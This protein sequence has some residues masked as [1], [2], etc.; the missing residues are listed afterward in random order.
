MTKVNI[1]YVGVVDFPKE[2]SPEEISTTIQRDILPNAPR[3]EARGLE[4]LTPNTKVADFLDKYL[5]KPAQALSNAL[6][7]TINPYKQFT[8]EEE[9]KERPLLAA[10]AKGII[11]FS[12]LPVEDKLS[13]L[14]TNQAADKNKYGFHY[15]NAP[16][17]E[18]AGIKERD[19]AVNNYLYQKQQNQKSKE[20]TTEKYGENLITKKLNKLDL[21]D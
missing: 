5:S 14:L 11:G 16:P 18:M 20:L 17:E 2:M 9:P 13:T 12:E 1:P 21:D 8:K 3:P 10:F 6:P 19:I 15:E 4:T 7:I